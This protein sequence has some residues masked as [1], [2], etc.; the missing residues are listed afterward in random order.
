MKNKTI[1]IKSI[2]ESE[3][4][5]ADI[6]EITN[7]LKQHQLYDFINSCLEQINLH[8]KQ[9]NLSHNRKGILNVAPIGVM[10]LVKFNE[11]FR[12]LSKNGEITEKEKLE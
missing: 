5:N 9:K 3:F 2:I 10:M 8:I 4:I 6:L 11:Y 1:T 7:E 12:E